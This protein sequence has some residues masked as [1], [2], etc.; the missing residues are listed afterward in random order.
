MRRSVLL[1]LG[2]LLGTQA[3]AWEFTPGLPCLLAHDE[4]RIS[5]ELS[6]DPSAPLY[7]ISIT[8]TSP[9]PPGD[10]F[11]IR[12]EGPRGLTISTGQHILSEGGRRLTVTDRGFGNV[13]NGLQFN[14]GMVAV[15]GP[16]EVAFSLEGAAK[17]VAAF[18]ACDGLPSV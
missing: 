6:F 5:V 18:R 15:L 7:T 3:A 2:L 14:R 13:L 4:G 11:A 8:R 12:F 1:A 10:I 17:P 16:T 9:W